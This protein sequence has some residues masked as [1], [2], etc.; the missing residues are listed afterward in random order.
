[1]L[2]P[3]D[4]PTSPRPGPACLDGVGL[5]ET[6]VPTGIPPREKKVRVLVVEDETLV[7]CLIREIVRGRFECEVDVVANG[8]AAFERLA[9]TRYALVVSDVRMPEMNGAELYLWLREAQPATA[10]SFVFVTAYAEERHF[11]T[12]LAAWGVPIVAKPFTESQFL[13]VCG[14]YLDRSLDLPAR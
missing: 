5:P 9:H 13:A 12:K 6:E 3:M 11:E 8:V 10:Q 7:A 4:P 1:M 2:L 14:P